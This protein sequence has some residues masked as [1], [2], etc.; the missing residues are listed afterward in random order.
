M[1]TQ[2]SIEADES[3]EGELVR[4]RTYFPILKQY[5]EVGDM[6]SALSLFKRMQSTPG[7][8]LEPETYVLLLASIAENKYFW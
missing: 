1:S 7:V 6:S 4:L 8:M 5:C 2:K 3:S